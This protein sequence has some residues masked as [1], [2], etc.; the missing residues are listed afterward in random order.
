MHLDNYIRPEVAKKRDKVGVMMKSIYKDL[1]PYHNKAEFPRFIV[2][3]I[4]KIGINGTTVSKADGGQGM[5]ILEAG[6]LC[7]EF[8]RYDSSVAGLFLV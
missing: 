5:T 6:A 4:Q 3:L 1:I 7:Y 2:P 8:A